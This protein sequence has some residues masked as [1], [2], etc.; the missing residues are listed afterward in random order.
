MSGLFK[1]RFWYPLLVLLF[2]SLYMACSSP[3]G[4]PETKEVNPA[5]PANSLPQT[6]VSAQSQQ[7]WEREWDKTLSEA[8]K[9]GQVIITAG[10]GTV[11]AREPFIRAMKEKF[12]ID[13]EIIVSQGSPM[14][15]RVLSE[16]RA[17]IY[18]NDLYLGGANTLAAEMF[19]RNLVQPIEPYLILPEVKNPALWFKGELPVWGPNRVAFFSILNITSHTSV[20]KNLV[21][22]EEITSYNDLLKPKLKG[23]IAMYDPTL[24]SGGGKSFFMQGYRFMG[25]DYMK[26]LVKQEP[27]LTRDLRLLTEWLVSGK[28]PVTLGLSGDT[29]SAA[30][31]DG[32]P[33]AMLP[34]LKEGAIVGPGAGQLAVWDNGPHPNAT[35]VFVNWLLSKEGMTVFAKAV[36][37]ASR[38]ADVPTN[39]LDAYMVPDAK[40]NYVF[41]NQEVLDETERLMPVAKDIF[42]PLLR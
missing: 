3:A 15:Q 37:M 1:V 7:A 28:F 9:E 31:K 18:R 38:R 23:K 20:S 39:H 17:G 26:E 27:V 22:P 6:G 13:A 40:A 34:V 35:K 25:A 30:E 41:E 4:P 11:S 14:M 8:K 32:Y 2:A 19:T 16:R 42:G 33:V 36:N 24:G 29:V 12:G 21:K 5:Q 10:Y